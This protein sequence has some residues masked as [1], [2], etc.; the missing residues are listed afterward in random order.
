[1]EDEIEPLVVSIKCTA[2]N[3]EPYIRQ[4]LEGFVMQKT[5]FR[6]EA[7]VHDDA[8]TDGTAAI[9]REYAEKYPDIIKP[10]YETENQYSKHDGSLDRIMDAHMHGKYIAL[11]EGDDYWIDP[12]KL[13]KQVDFL[14]NRLEYGLVNTDVNVLYQEESFLRKQYNISKSLWNNKFVNG[15]VPVVYILSGQY[16]IKTP[17]VLLRRELY[18]DYTKSIDYLNILQRGFLMGDTPLWVYIA[19]HSRLGYIDE[20]TTVYRRNKNSVSN[21]K[22]LLSRLKFLLSSSELRMY[23]IQ[24]YPEFFSDSFKIRV[25]K[26]F[27]RRL[28]VYSCFDLFY[29]SVFASSMLRRRVRTVRSSYSLRFLYKFCYVIYAQSQNV[30]MNMYHK[31]RLS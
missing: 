14:E 26:I 6:F 28:L 27:E 16:F 18:I 20:V 9:I 31:M 5:N 29:D 4:C 10:I 1:M 15:E 7:I 12:L 17:T 22:Y 30:L 25:N 24:Y 23:Y 19:Q 11:C 21:S 3:H 2:Y 8:S 13:Q